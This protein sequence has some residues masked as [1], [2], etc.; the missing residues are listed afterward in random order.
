VI[1]CLNEL[2]I[3]Y[4]ISVCLS[5]F[6]PCWGVLLCFLSHIFSW[7]HLLVLPVLSL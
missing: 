2:C 5:V 6:L 1:S 4:F 7:L 3:C